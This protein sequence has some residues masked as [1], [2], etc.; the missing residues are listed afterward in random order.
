MLLQP[1]PVHTRMRK[2]VFSVKLY[3]TTIRHK[4]QTVSM[5]HETLYVFV[6]F[7]TFKNVKTGRTKTRFSPRSTVLVSRDEQDQLAKRQTSNPVS[8]GVRL[9]AT[10]PG[11]KTV[12]FASR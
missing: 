1:Q 7:Q 3:L 6:S 10:L 12:W 8:T 4:S 11:N 5:C 2:A 9:T